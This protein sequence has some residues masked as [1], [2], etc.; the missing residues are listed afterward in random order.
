MDANAWK[1]KGNEAFSAKDFPAAI[2]AFGEAI[3]L[4]ANNH[5]LWSNRSAAHASLRNFPEALSDA[6][7]CVAIKADWAKGY[8]RLGAAHHGLREYE[9]AIEAYEE[10]LKIEPTNAS[11]NEALSAVQK[12]AQSSFASPFAKIFTKDCVEKIRTNPKIAPYM[13]QPDFVVILGKVIEDPSQIQQYLKDRRMMHV[14]MELSGINIPG[15]SDN[16]AAD[17]EEE[18]ER[19]RAAK[20]KADAEKK[21]EDAKKAAAAAAVQ[22]NQEAIKL[23]EE[24]NEF[25]KQRKF[26]EA[27]AK[28]DAAVALE[29]KNSTFLL[30]RTAV[31]FEKQEYDTCIAECEKALEHVREHN[32]ND[33][34]LVGKLLTRQAFCN[35][36]LKKYDEAIAIYKKA[37]VEWRNPDTLA[38][39][40]ACEKEKKV[41]EEE[42]YLNPEIAAAKK[43][44][45]NK[46]FKEDKFPLAVECYSESIK[47]NPKEHTTFSNRAAAYLKLGA[48]NEALL[49]CEKCLSINP[50]FVKAIARKG[51][52][53]FWTKQYNKA[54]QA[55]DDGLK[56]DAA[57]AE[58]IEGKQKT[59]YKIQ[60]MSQGDGDED[61]ARRAMAD[62]EIAAI[63]QDSY[64]QMIL[65]E[66]QKN[67][68]RINE[69][70]KD[71]GISE[72][73]NKL[74]AAGI[75]RVGNESQ[76]QAGRR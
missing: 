29:P 4:D 66:M 35:Q 37:L 54:L 32:K 15:A 72:K 14:F 44:E 52:A 9:E 3:K 20:A 25:Y 5:I 40:T 22:G 55:Y 48:Y 63:M 62:P 49:D 50:T 61:A 56:L 45:G 68:A 73:I 6:K 30:N 8:Q 46:Y 41:S 64:M 24:G 19:R 59:I 26:D 28:Y 69:Y 39:L 2:E 13:M 42:A 18:A 38:K 21:A 34:Q 27:M 60:E 58:C 7:R 70:M 67:P 17:P 11:L 12:E 74:I 47:R 51:H 43:D 75:I 36:K 16:F 10:G 23:K 1:A 71:K 76:A 31:Y 33:Y 57:N 65:S 53:Y